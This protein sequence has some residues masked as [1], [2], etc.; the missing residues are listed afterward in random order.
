MTDDVTYLDLDENGEEDN[1]H[2]RAMEK[3][4]RKPKTLLQTRALTACRKSSK[5]Y[6]SVAQHKKIKDFEK[7]CSGASEASYLNLQWGFNC[8]EV[9]EKA[10]ANTLTRGIDN[11]LAYMHNESARED[12]ITRNRVRLL[13]ERAST[14]KDGLE[15]MIVKK[16]AVTQKERSVNDTEHFDF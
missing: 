2:I 10:N 16:T 15:K 5:R 14:S 11:L 12:W 3:N 6:S 9:W 1:A 7:L 8:C 4:A 13:K